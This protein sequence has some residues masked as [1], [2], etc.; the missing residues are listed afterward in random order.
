MTWAYKWEMGDP[1]NVYA[2]REAIQKRLDMTQDESEQVDELLM[3]WYLWS[4]RY[5]LKLGAPSKATY[6]T[7]PSSGDVH[8]DPEDV[9][10]RVE[11]EKASQIDACIDNLIWQ[12]RS[13]VDVHCANRHSGNKVMNNPRIDKAAHVAFYKEAKALLLPMF[14]RRGMIRECDNYLQTK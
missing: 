14:R 9:D 7:I 2:R 6:Y 13:A 12:Q 10:D 5:K 4:L 11:S 3:A 1:F 8:A